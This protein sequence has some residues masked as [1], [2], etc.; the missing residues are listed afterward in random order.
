MIKRLMSIVSGLN[1]R[2]T[3]IKAL[4][5]WFLFGTCAAIIPCIPGYIDK[6]LDIPCRMMENG[7]GCHVRKGNLEIGFG[8]EKL[9]LDENED[10]EKD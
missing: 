5:G 10:N 7:Y 6:T 8:K 4:A 3:D 9:Q 1:L 2:P